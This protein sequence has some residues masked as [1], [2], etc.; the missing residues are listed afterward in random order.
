MLRTS[1]K[2]EISHSATEKCFKAGKKGNG[3]FI[4]FI[5]FFDNINY[6]SAGQSLIALKSVISFSSKFNSYNLG[7]SLKPSRFFNLFYFISNI[8]NV[9]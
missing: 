2:F 3:A 1:V 7:I 5:L 8:S 9:G 4:F 6:L